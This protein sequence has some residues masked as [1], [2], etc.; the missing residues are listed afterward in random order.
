MKPYGKSPSRKRNRPLYESR[1][2]QDR[3]EIDEWL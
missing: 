1:D 3:Q 2:R